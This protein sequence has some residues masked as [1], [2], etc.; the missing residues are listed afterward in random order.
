MKKIQSVRGMKDVLPSDCKIYSGLENLLSSSASQ[1][2]YREIRTPILEDSELLL[3][4]EGSKLFNN[5]S[6]YLNDKFGFKSI[7]FY[8]ETDVQICKCGLKNQIINYEVPKMITKKY[9][10]FEK[11]FNFFDK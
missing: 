5:N 6:F 7:N 2:G 4:G 9:G 11:F 8:T 3:I 10:I 1:F